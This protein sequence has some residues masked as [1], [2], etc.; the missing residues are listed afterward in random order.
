M[1]NKAINIW[2]FVVAVLTIAIVLFLLI[3]PLNCASCV[4]TALVSLVARLFGP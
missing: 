1:S 3:H 4:S 2:C